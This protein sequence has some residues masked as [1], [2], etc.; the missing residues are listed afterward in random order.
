MTA[1][2]SPANPANGNGNG[3]GNGR[4]PGPAA[5]SPAGDPAKLTPEMIRQLLPRTQ[6]LLRAQRKLTGCLAGCFTL[7][8]L[9]ILAALY[10]PYWDYANQ[11]RE[12]VRSHLTLLREGKIEEARAQLDDVSA[13]EFDAQLKRLGLLELLRDADAITVL[14]FSTKNGAHV[15]GEIHPTNVEMPSRPFRV[16]VYVNDHK[17]LRIGEF[18]WHA[19]DD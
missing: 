3:N 1:P 16:E 12:L 17:E 7:L 6:D 18:M 13:A 15:P 19:L 9:G 8:I 10:I 11:A 14:D 2:D 5:A 4:P